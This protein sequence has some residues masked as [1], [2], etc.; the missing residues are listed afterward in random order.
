M[1]T[2][3]E[4]K[5]YIS[6]FFGPASSWKSLYSNC[7]AIHADL[8]PEI[9]Q[10]FIKGLDMMGVKSYKA[11][12]GT[13]NKDGTTHIECCMFLNKGLSLHVFPG[14]KDEGKAWDIWWDNLHYFDVP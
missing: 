2:K 12:L 7:E 14:L 11:C 8:S 5:Q 13:R 1:L 3:E 9:A 6:N 10:V 4:T